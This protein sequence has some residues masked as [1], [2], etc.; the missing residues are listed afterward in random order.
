VPRL[1][2]LAPDIAKAIMDGQQAPEMTLPVLMGP[3]PME[4]ERQR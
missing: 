3:F 2:L 1:A 4:W